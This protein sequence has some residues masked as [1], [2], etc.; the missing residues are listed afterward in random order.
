[1]GVVRT[2]ATL[3]KTKTLQVGTEGVEITVKYA[4]TRAVIARQNLFDKVRY[5]SIGEEGE[6]ATERSFPMGDLRLETV[7]MV[8]KDWNLEDDKGRKQAI[9]HNSVLNLLSPEELMETYDHVIDMNKVWG[10]EAKEDGDEGEASA[11]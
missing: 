1:M 11:S 8:I 4:D 3:A 6:T 2:T 5:I 7:M 10:G 9:N